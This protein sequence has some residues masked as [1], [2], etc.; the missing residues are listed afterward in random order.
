MSIKKVIAGCLALVVVGVVVLTVGA[1]LLE[2]NPP[3]TKE[4]NWDSPQTHELAQRACFDCHSNE[5]AW[6]WYSRLPVGSWVAVF[7]TVRGRREINFSEWDTRR[8][9]EG[10]EDREAEEYAE[11]IQE[12]EMP[13]AM[14]LMMHPEA[15]LSDQE[16]Q[17]LIRGLQ[18]SLK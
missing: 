17:Q 15:K 13:P 10:R 5:T 11:V 14:Y 3:V 8:V 12:G 4:P 18:D 7:D 9:R 2:T 1:L 6:P 16:K